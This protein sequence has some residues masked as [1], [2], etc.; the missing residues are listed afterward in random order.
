MYGF[1][2]QKQ[3]SSILKKEVA[4]EGPGNYGKTC[5][6]LNKLHPLSAFLLPE[7]RFC[8]TSAFKIQPQDR[9]EEE[10][11]KGKETEVDPGQKCAVA[12]SPFL[13]T[14]GA[15]WCRAE[16]SLSGES[17]NLGL[18]SSTGTLVRPAG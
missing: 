2:K 16:K 11:H 3:Y 18:A 8:I 9:A 4:P 7:L 17:Q 10:M 1:D 5:F 6:S 14:L 15:V 12:P 13:P